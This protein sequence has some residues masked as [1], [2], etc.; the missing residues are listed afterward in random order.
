MKIAF[1]LLISFGAALS[2]ITLVDIHEGESQLQSFVQVFFSEC[3]LIELAHDALFQIDA[4][5]FILKPLNE[6]MYVEL[7]MFALKAIYENDYPG[8][9]ELTSDAT[10]ILRAYCEEISVSKKNIQIEVDKIQR[11]RNSSG[12]IT[13]SANILTEARNLRMKFCKVL[14]VLMEFDNGAAEIEYVFKETAPRMLYLK[15]YTNTIQI[16]AKSEELGFAKGA[17]AKEIIDKVST[18]ALDLV[19]RLEKMND[20]IRSDKW[21]QIL[22]YAHLESYINHTLFYVAS[23]LEKVVA[24]WRSLPF[25]YVLKTDQVNRI[26]AK[27][28]N[29]AISRK[30][31]N[32]LEA[33]FLQIV[34]ANDDEDRRKLT[35]EIF[36]KLDEYTMFNI[37]FVTLVYEIVD[38]DVFKSIPKGIPVMPQEYKLENFRHI[39]ADAEEEPMVV[40]LWEGLQ[41]EIQAPTT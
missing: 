7:V 31:V 9:P 14:A 11:A 24:L 16:Y 19:E 37:E 32:E 30:V 4:A 40:W 15:S 29:I 21:K 22:V 3:D 6:I 10:V 26:N 34:Q 33:I 39:N 8:K 28:E 23:V 35:E 36:A 1:L 13:E 2:A 25:D 12:Y 5:K 41:F 18:I 17:F 27:F 38:V 20:I